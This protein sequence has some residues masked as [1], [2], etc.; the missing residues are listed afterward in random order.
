MKKIIKIAT[1]LT[2]L[3]L[4]F[5][6]ITTYAQETRKPAVAVLF[7]NMAKT[8]Y[9]DDLAKKLV[10]HIN[11]KLISSYNVVSGKRYVEKLSKMGIADI[12]MA[13]QAEITD[14][15]KNQNVDFVVFAEID[16][17][18]ITREGSFFGGGNKAIVTVS[19]KIVDV[20]NNKFLYNSRFIEEGDNKGF[21]FDNYDTKGGVLSA[22]DKIATRIDE[23]LAKN[24]PLTVIYDE[25]E[26]KLQSKDEKTWPAV[27]NVAQA[28]EYME[29]DTTTVNELIAKKAINATKI[30]NDWFVNKIN[31]DS[32]PGDHSG[33]V[34]V[35]E[36][37][38]KTLSLFA[39]N[40]YTPFGSNV[41]RINQFHKVI[42][43]DKSYNALLIGIDKYKIKE[44]PIT[45][46]TLNLDGIE[47]NLT[48]LAGVRKEEDVRGTQAWYE[49]SN[50]LLIKIINAK[51]LTAKVTMSNGQV[52]NDEPDKDFKDS[53]QRIYSIGKENYYLQPNL[54][55]SKNTLL[56]FIP[57]TTPIELGQRLVYAHNFDNSKGKD[58]FLYAQSYEVKKTDDWQSVNFIPRSWVNRDNYPYI[59]IDLQQQDNGTWVSFN[60]ANVNRT[61]GWEDVDIRSDASEDY[62]RLV[63]IWMISLEN[64]Y[65]IF[66]GQYNY[67]IEW[68]IIDEEKNINRINWRNGPFIITKVNTALPELSQ[69]N[70][71]DII[72]AIDGVPTKTMAYADSILNTFYYG[73][74]VIFTLVDAEGNRKN[75]KINPKFL[76][77]TTPKKNYEEILKKGWGYEKLE[78]HN[79]R[80]VYN[81]LGSGYQ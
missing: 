74:P 63:N 1:L 42:T 58:E 72:A 78:S 33:K 51:K 48:P 13:T 77:S 64:A 79:S 56:L 76:P 12:T 7:V 20:A 31:I 22:L 55:P 50:D 61:R 18:L 14:A 16:P 65:E 69:I 10:E 62:M 15:F 28:A 25:A 11:L 53:I 60:V 66:H 44:T 36:G 24:I 54:Y 9:D 45:G 26:Q 67:G 71:G 19:V 34:F 35:H 3:L 57:G 2:T 59:Y 49:I 80:Q 29:I 21:I 32:F 39:M 43:A 73:K 4:L 23:A 8:K 38:D 46:T 27:M 75:I 70:K 81:P 30:G 6:V 17:V 40:I 47:Y 37:P 5:C 52:Y 41:M 68:K